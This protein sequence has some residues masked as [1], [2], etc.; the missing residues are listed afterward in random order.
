MC[1]VN[2]A[3]E[4]LKIKPSARDIFLPSVEKMMRMLKDIS[5]QY[6]SEYDV[7]GVNDPFL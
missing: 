4:I 3:T 6:S 7:D 5:G 1:A 2:L